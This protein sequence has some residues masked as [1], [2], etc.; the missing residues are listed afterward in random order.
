M[1]EVKEGVLFVVLATVCKKVI[2][3]WQPGKMGE[4]AMLPP[5][6]KGS[7]QNTCQGPEVGVC[8]E[9]SHNSG[10]LTVVEESK[11]GGWV[12]GDMGVMGKGRASRALYQR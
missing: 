12:G 3:E 11:Q 7:R 8:L 1:I 5:E 4:Q 2:L 6:R 9:Y 10:R